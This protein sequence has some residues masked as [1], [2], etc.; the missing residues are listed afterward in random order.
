V[1]LAEYAELLPAW[2][3]AVEAALADPELDGRNE[4]VTAL[5]EDWPSPTLERDV[6]GVVHA[7]ENGR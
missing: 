4:V 1:A 7:N 5:R 2:V 3:D 6:Q